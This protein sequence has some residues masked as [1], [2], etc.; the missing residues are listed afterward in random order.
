[1][2]ILKAF[3]N[4]HADAARK[5]WD[6]IYVFMDLHST[7]I[8]PNYK[9]G[10][11]PTEFYK[12]ALEALKLLYIAKDTKLIMYTCSHPHEIEQYE[13]L[14]LRHGIRFD[15]INENPEVTTTPQ[16]YGCYDMKPYFN[17]LFDDKAGFDATEDWQEVLDYLHGRY[18][19]EVRTSEEWYETTSKRAGITILDPDGWR[20]GTCDFKKDLITWA[21]YENRLIQCTCMWKPIKRD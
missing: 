6:Y 15:Y 5:G 8:K 20:D 12:G 2:S 16:G 18:G 14:F 4:A 7:L 19:G 10:E 9:S 1:M 17:V 3:D 21:D 13:R 11:V